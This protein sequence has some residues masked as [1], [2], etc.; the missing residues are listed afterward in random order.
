MVLWT[1]VLSNDTKHLAA[2]LANHQE[3]AF[4]NDKSAPRCGVADGKEADTINVCH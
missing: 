2:K 3:K 4:C 1:H